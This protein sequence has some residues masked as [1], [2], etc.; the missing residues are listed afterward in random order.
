[1]GNV[2]P[3]IPKLL[4][5]AEV[6]A[7]AVLKHANKHRSGEGGDF[8][9]YAVDVTVG[10][11]CDSGVNNNQGFTVDME[12]GIQIIQAAQGII[13]RRAAIVA[14]HTTFAKGLKR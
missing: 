9:F 1:M 6:E 3:N 2:L 13:K 4:A 12:T 10:E 14:R 8:A 7:A 11:Q 5:D